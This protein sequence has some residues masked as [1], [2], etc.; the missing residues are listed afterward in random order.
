MKLVKSFAAYLP[1]LKRLRRLATSRC[2]SKTSVEVNDAPGF[3][4]NRVL[5]PL[6]NEAMF[7]VMEGVATPAAIDEVFKLGMAH[8]MGP[9]ALADF[10]GLD[11]CLDIMRVLQEGLG[12][13]KYRPCP[14]LIKMVD[15]GWLGKKSGRGFYV[16]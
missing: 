8:P 16:Y 4:S 7:A 2:E 6:L 14:L 12:D 11:V 1:R 3:V 10:I 9:L 13:P 15:A 5:M